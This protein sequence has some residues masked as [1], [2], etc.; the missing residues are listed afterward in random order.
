VRL[1][2]SGRLVSRLSVKRWMASLLRLS[3]AS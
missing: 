3:P 1:P 2:G